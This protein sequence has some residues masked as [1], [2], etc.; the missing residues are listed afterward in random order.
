MT[1][2]VELI[3]RA[4]QLLRE[5]LGNTSPKKGCRTAVSE[6]TSD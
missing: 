2:R 6:I 5:R 3:D 4:D 1:G